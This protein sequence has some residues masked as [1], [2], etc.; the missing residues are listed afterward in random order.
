MAKML[1][2]MGFMFREAG[3]ALD[4]LGMR[5]MGNEA[6]KEQRTPRCE[7]AIRILP[8]ASIASH[9]SSPMIN[10]IAIHPSR[11]AHLAVHAKCLP[12]TPP[13]PRLQ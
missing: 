9:P 8:S 6:F 2:S 5:L 1:Y 13:C 4:R 11:Q 3:Q 12:L 10:R 7:P